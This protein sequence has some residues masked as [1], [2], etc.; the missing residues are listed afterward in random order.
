MR[1]KIA[2]SAVRL[3]PWAPYWTFDIAWLETVCWIGRVM[4]AHAAS[5]FG[6][7][8]EFYLFGLTLLGIAAFHKRALEISV[9]G[10]LVILAYEWLISAFPTGPGPEGFLLHAEHEW[11]TI[12]NL[13]LLL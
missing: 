10:L 4:T 13:L 6:A 11:V 2:V 8:V 1:L 3:R 9:T 5:L 7:P 12:A